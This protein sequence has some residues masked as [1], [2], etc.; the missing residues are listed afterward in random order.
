MKL[1]AATAASFAVLGFMDGQRAKS[2][3]DTAQPDP[4]TNTRRGK[5]GKLQRV[6]SWHFPA[7]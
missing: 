5:R 7:R 3:P 6:G 2:L 4:A 1:N